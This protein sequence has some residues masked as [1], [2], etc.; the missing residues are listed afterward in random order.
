MCQIELRSRIGQCKAGF[1]QV[2][3]LEEEGR[4]PCVSRE[5]QGFSRLRRFGPL[6]FR[7]YGLDLLDGVHSEVKGC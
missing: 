3:G 7:F 1:L 2:A 6:D 4:V 5:C